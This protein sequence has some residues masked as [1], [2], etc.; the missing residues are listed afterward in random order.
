MG[1]IADELMQALQLL[2]NRDPELINIVSVSLQVTS[3]PDLNQKGEVWRQLYNQTHV[4]ETTRC[5]PAHC[6]RPG[7]KVDPQL[8]KQLFIR[9]ERRKATS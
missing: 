1:D 5:T 6:Y 3:L 7:L 8:L 4:N 2:L 9:E